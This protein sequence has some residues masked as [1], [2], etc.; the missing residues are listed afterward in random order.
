MGKFWQKTVA[1]CVTG[2]TAYT[3][4]TRFATT[5]QKCLAT[6]LVKAWLFKVTKICTLGGQAFHL[7]NGRCTTILCLANIQT[8]ISRWFLYIYATLYFSTIVIIIIIII[9]HRAPLTNNFLNN[10]GH[11]VSSLTGKEREGSF[12]FQHIPVLIK[13]FNSVFKWPLILPTNK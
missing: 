7:C 11:R 9:V 8:A 13:R 1:Q 3:M 6:R 12:V 10:L 2:F 5:A 4:H